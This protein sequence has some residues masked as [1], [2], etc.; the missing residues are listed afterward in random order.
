MMDIGLCRLRRIG[1]NVL[2]SALHP[3]HGLTW[4]DGNCIY[5]VPIN[6][7]EDEVGN[8]SPMKLGEFDHVSSLHWSSDTGESHCYLCVVHTSVVSLWKVDGSS[9]KLSFKQIRKIHATPILQGCLW[10]PKRD[11]LCIMNKEQCT[12]Y[13]RHLN[14][15]GSYSLPPIESGKITCGCW[16][17]DGENLI[18]GIKSIIVK[19]SSDSSKLVLFELQAR[20]EMPTKL[21]SVN[22]PGILGPD[23]LYCDGFR[24]M[25]VVGSNCQNSLHIYKVLDNEFH[26]IQTMEG[27]LVMV[28]RVQQSDPAF[29]PSSLD[30]EYTMKLSF[31]IIMTE[32]FVIANAIILFHSQTGIEDNSSCKITWKK[33]LMSFKEN[34]S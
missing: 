28:G 24:N 30:M 15:R 9:P 3:R 8:N 13:F 26:Q 27:L 14:K 6:I 4:T 11:V 19:S 20:G 25:I 10:N 5:L 34:Y 18:V 16:T 33:S 7:T 21:H 17:L 2:H 22:I 12:F 23:L 1:L 31:K 29:L 32:V